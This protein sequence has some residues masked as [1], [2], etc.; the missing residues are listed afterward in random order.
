[1]DYV[2]QAITLFRPYIRGFI[3]LLLALYSINQFLGLIGQPSLS[4]GALL[5]LNSSSGG[6]EGTMIEEKHKYLN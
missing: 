5:M 4:L 6:S 3:M 1:M 2:I